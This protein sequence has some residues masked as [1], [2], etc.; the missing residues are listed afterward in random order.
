MAGY[1][2]SADRGVEEEAVPLEDDVAIRTLLRGVET[3]AVLGIKDGDGDDAFRVPR[4]MQAAGYRLL[5][6]NPK[7]QRVL[8]EPCVPGLADVEGPVD[9]VNVFRAAHHL[10]LHAE[11]ILNLPQHPRAVWLQLGIRDDAV[12]ARLEEAGITVVQ[13]RCLMVEHARLLGGYAGRRLDV[14]PSG[15]LRIRV[16]YDFASSL[17]YVAHRSMQR[18]APQLAG[19]EIELEWSPLDLAALLGWVRG[20][21][22]DAA[23]LANVERVS[24]ELDVPLR[25]PPVWLDSRRAHAV[26]LA[27]AGER[28]PAWLER[29]WTAVFEEGRALDDESVDALARGLS[30]P[31]D[32]TAVERGLEELDARTRSAHTQEVSGVPNFMLGRWPFGGIQTDDTML[33]IL[34]RFARRQRE[35]TGDA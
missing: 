22:V 15:R 12:A 11:E 16:D 6:V 5:P 32:E 27:A 17:C 2:T 35:R 1:S 28:A 20:A 3:I 18:L 30:I 23:R 31:L 21:D 10:P 4:Y 13:D 9:L 24:R 26:A 29:V 33:S 25:V 7:L 34:S 8:D 14:E 19:L